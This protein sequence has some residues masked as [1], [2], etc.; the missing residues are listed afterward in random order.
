V[1][2][3]NLL[4]QALSEPLNDTT[5]ATVD[6]N[7]G[8]GNLTIDTLPDEEHEH[9]LAS[10]TLQYFEKE[11][12]PTRSV[13]SDHGRATLKLKARD[14]RRSWLRIPWAGCGGATEWQIHLNP[15]VSSDITA[16]TD[17]GNVKLNLA[18]MAVTR[19]SADTGGGNM[20]VVLPDNAADLAAVARMGGGNVTVEIGDA[21][22]GGNALNASSGAG[23]VIVRVPSGVAASV[24]A[25]S[26][27]GRVSVEPR[28]SKVGANSYQSPEYDTA[29]SKVEI[30]LSSGA[31]NVIVSTK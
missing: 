15:M 11:G 21:I 20:D 7:S 18:S 2:N 19:V 30:T 3:N 13:Q 10:A 1:A 8:I 14:A 28:F 29:T 23:N 16:H 4:T 6:I 31:G 22:T 12:M 26:G 25:T 5:T 27:L 9:E 17:G 24:H